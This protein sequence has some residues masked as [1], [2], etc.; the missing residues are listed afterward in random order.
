MYFIFSITSNTVFLGDKLSWHNGQ[1]FT[2]YDQDH[3]NNANSYGNSNC[4]I[5][6]YGAWWYASCHNS[7]LNGHYG[8]NSFG[9]GINWSSITSYY[10]S[11]SK[12]E[13]KIKKN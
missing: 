6:F 9:K 7:N 4:A 1:P 13:M 3:D 10:S 5:A 2:T 11:L 8:N 12:V